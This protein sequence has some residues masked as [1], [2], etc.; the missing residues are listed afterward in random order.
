MFIQ[1]TK[2]SE[3]NFKA[4]R[5]KIWKG[6]EA[7]AIDVIGTAGG[8]GI[9]WNLLEVSLTR[10]LATRYTIFMEFHIIATS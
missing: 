5:E 3:I 8:L 2:C 10:F 1:E 6:N 9:I 4:T 7:V